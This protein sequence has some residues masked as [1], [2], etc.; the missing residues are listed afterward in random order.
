MDFNTFISEKFTSYLSI[1]IFWHSQEG[2][3]GCAYEEPPRSCI[4]TLTF[5]ADSTKQFIQSKSGY[6]I[7]SVL[8][9][10]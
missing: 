10:N 8:W 2:I 1:T 9:I 3:Y 5:S 7:I 4:V 6:G